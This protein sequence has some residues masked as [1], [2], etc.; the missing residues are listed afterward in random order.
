MPKPSIWVKRTPKPVET[1]PAENK[2]LRN[3]PKVVHTTSGRLITISAPKKLLPKNDRN[4]ANPRLGSLAQIRMAKDKEFPPIPSEEKKPM[5]QVPRSPGIS[6]RE[7]Y[8]RDEL[9]EKDRKEQEEKEINFQ[10]ECREGL[11]G[12]QCQEYVSFQNMMAILNMVTIQE[13]RWVV[14]NAYI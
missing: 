2:P 13:L 9:M 3:T 6:P 4:A 7:Q 14:I 10:E 1:K 12:R 11:R 5:I 8:R